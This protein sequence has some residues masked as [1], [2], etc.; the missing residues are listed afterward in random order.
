M[1][2]DNVAILGFG[3]SSMYAIMACNDLGIKP[4]VICIGQPKYPAGTFY[5]HWLPKS[6]R[7]FI[8]EE[9]IVYRYMGTEDQYLINQYG[10]KN[11]GKSSFGRYSDCLFVPGYDPQRVMAFVEE[12]LSYS[13]VAIPS[14]LEDWEVAILCE[15]YSKV[16]CSF[17]L[18]GAI[19]RYDPFML[20]PV[21]AEKNDLEHNVIVY[22]GTTDHDWVRKSYLFGMCYTEYAS[23]NVPTSGNL[24]TVIDLK[25][26]V[27]GSISSGLENL[28]LI[29]RLACMD[30]KV[31]A[32][33]AYQ[34]VYGVLSDAK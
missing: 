17:A 9:E 33:D 13:V 11:A 5:L 7:R 12:K 20:I 15:K 6:V 32:H 8:S 16:F 2:S 1:A 26:H 3:P 10:T 4:E 34:K 19:H 18:E 27:T 31:L 24:V 14:R 23:G 30:R 28:T 29:G 25:P 21:V 22:N